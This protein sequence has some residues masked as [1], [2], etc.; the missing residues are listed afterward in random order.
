MA[1]EPEDGG[2]PDATF[3]KYRKNPTWYPDYLIQNGL[4]FGAPYAL[5]GS[6]G[7]DQPNEQWDP[8]S[9][10]DTMYAFALWILREYDRWIDTLPAEQRVT[11][12][13]ASK[14]TLVR[15]TF[16]SYNFHDVPPGFNLGDSRLRVMV[17][18]FAKHR[19]LGKWKAFRTRL[20]IVK[21]LQVWLPKPSADYR[22]LSNAYYNDWTMSGLP[23]LADFS[24]TAIS[25]DYSTYYDAGVRAMA[26]ETDFNFGKFGLGYYLTAKKLWNPAMSARQL[27]AIRDQWLQRSFGN[28]WRTMKEYY[29]FLLAPNYPVNST[30]SWGHA[31]QLIADADSQIPAAE[32]AVKSRIDDLKQYWY[33]Y[34]LYDTGKMNNT[35]P[36]TREFVWKGQM[37]YMNAMYAL[38]R[39]VYGSTDAAAVA[40]PATSSGP[41]HYAAVET[42]SWWQQVRAHWPEVNVDR[43]DDATLADG[44]P[45]IGIDQND[46]TLVDEFVWPG[47][48]GQFL[49]NAGYQTSGVFLTHANQGGQTIGFK[50]WW[51][52]L[53]ESAFAPRN[54]YYGVERWNPSGLSWEAVLDQS[55]TAQPS[56][57]M[58]TYRLVQAAISAP[59]AGIFRFS[60]G[61]AGNVARLAPL[62]YDIDASHSTGRSP[63]T[64]FKL[65]SGLTQLPVYSYIPKG[66]HSLDLDV[67]DHSGNKKLRIY[68]ALLSKNPSAPY[69]DVDIS[70]MKT[71]RIP[72]Q[73]GE[74]GTITR[75]SGNGF[76]FP[77]LHS[78]PQLWAMSPA[79]LMV[80]RA[81]AAADGL[82]V[83]GG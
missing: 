28:A 75:I 7:L 83:A 35:A 68:S 53:G 41:A 3:V 13:G 17:A 15:A 57:D 71:H 69:R 79:E 38:M 19:G 2:V 60:L 78:V 76:A 14:K 11:S 21:A 40:G 25:E 77:Y 46:L 80:P 65:A 70:A 36:E 26:I 9:Q 45:A 51:P 52:K 73:P 62:T 56:V 82:T 59:T 6:Y 81:I 66:T 31:I 61:Y 16:Y 5:H 67:W 12:S 34:F 74:D 4:P 20:D 55:T 29:D 10:S 43:F 24:P 32:A 54:V 30:S 39:R 33:Y 18:G 23:A 72:L 47:S 44:T 50:L 42:A 58:P 48:Y 27:D 37:A 8:T 64:Y 22:I 1:I 49:Y 63:H